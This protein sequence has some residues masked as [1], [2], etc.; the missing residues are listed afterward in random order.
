MIRAKG[1][2]PAKYLKEEIMNKKV[3]LTEEQ[4]TELYSRV[5][6]EL[7]QRERNEASLPETFIKAFHA[8]FIFLQFMIH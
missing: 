4:E 1:E 6:W 7:L 3:I 5:I 2:D 8:P